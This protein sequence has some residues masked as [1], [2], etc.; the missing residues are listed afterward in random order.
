[1]L[2]L[3]LA[4]TSLGLCIALLIG[5]VVSQG[6]LHFGALLAVA[7][8]FAALIAVLVTGARLLALATGG[9][10]G[11]LFAVYRSLRMALLVTGWTAALSLLAVLVAGR[12]DVQAPVV[13]GILVAWSA[14]SFWLAR[15]V[16]RRAADEGRSRLPAPLVVAFGS[17]P[18]LVLMGFLLALLTPHRGMHP[19]VHP[20][21]QRIVC[22]NNAR[23][24]AI[25]C[26]E[27]A[28]RRGWLPYGGKNFVLGLAAHKL[29][30]IRNPDN[31]EV[32][33][34]PG[35]SEGRPRPSREAYVAVTKEALGLRRLPELT[36][37]AGRRNDEA[38]FRLQPGDEERSEPIVGCRLGEYVIVG[39][40]NGAAR[41]YDRED[42]GLGP[43]DPIVFGEGS[44][45]PIL[46]KLSDR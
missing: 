38:G 34:C 13:L 36:D 41:V 22:V 8:V 40:S 16:G 2:G 45:S 1:M 10:D 9:K 28:R 19:E 44:A 30:D 32:F 20:H 11:S 35:A 42:L 39:F 7:V 4:P 46:V 43:D 33:F 18:L 23:N 6:R 26:S 5:V 21:S 12:R 15:F 3:L 24:L 29:I 27:R 17:L 25:I 31:L 37:F 14:A